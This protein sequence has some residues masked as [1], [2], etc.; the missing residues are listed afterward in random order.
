[1]AHYGLQLPHTGQLDD[2]NYDSEAQAVRAA[3]EFYLEDAVVYYFDLTG[4]TPL[5]RAG[6]LADEL[7]LD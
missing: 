4:A 3:L 6:D 5:G 7:G 2:V 1:M